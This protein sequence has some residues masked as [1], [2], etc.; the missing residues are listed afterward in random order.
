MLI[1]LISFIFL[2]GLSFNRDL[3]QQ[4]RIDNPTAHVLHLIQTSGVAID[5]A[6][7]KPGSFI[8][9][10]ATTGEV[11]KLRE[12]GLNPKVLIEDLENFYQSRLTNDF[13][14]LDR[15]F[16]YGSMG[17]YYTLDEIYENLV[18]LSLNYPSLVGDIQV[19]G[20]SLEGRDIW[21]I[22]LSDNVDIDEDEPEVLY[23]GLHHAREPM[24][25][26]NLFYFMYWLVENY[27]TDLEARGILDNR[28]LWFIPA[29]NPDGLIYNQSIAPNGGG[30]QRKNARE[31]CSSTPDGTDL[32]RNYSFYWGYNE[33]G[34]SSDGCNETYRGSAPFSE[35]ESQ[36]I[37]D[38]VESHDF[39][40]AFNYHSYSNLMIY[41]YGFNPSITPPQSDLDIFVEYA[42][43][44]T[45]FNGYL[46][47]TGIETVGYTVNGEAC[48]WMYGEH[49]IIAFTPEIGNFNDGFWPSTNRIVPL[50][51]ENLYPNKFLARAA[52]SKYSL[53][54]SIDEGPYA[55]GEQYSINISIFNQGLGNSNG[56]VVLEV[57]GDGN[58]I[59]SD[60]TSDLSISSL[61]ARET[62]NL[63][64]VISFSVSP[65]SQAGSSENIVVKVFDGDSFIE[66]IN[67]QI[68]I[69]EPATLAEDAFESNSG[70]TAGASSD[71]ASSGI[72]ERGVPNQTV[73][74]GIIV[75]TGQDHSAVGSQCYVTGNT[76]GGS[77][78]TDDVDGGRTT[79]LSPAYDIEGYDV[80]LV[81]YWRWYTNNVGDNPNTDTWRVDVSSD[82]GVSWVNIEST[83]QSNPS[84]LKQ[85][86]VLTP[87][88]V[89]LSSTLQ[90]RF[91][92]EDSFNSGDTGTGGSIVEA[93]VD[94][95]KLEVFESS[96]S[97]YSQGD[98][99]ID[100][101]INILDIVL[102]VGYVLGDNNLNDLQVFL[103]DI[104]NDGMTNILDIVQVVSVILGS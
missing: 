46:P 15:D 1:K 7:S 60:S 97:T 55:I 49:Q 10:A 56:E 100:G 102:M 103:S 98:V 61:D 93:A 42:D 59:F 92:A 14:D 2:L 4:I 89:D 27:E 31:T 63:N 68:I 82:G 50:C 6:H 81:S 87:E 43:D 69:G 25:Y 57:E 62:V 32:N 11:L 36:A 66:S 99:N 3:Y 84:W 65:S 41:P 12:I 67:L 18:D 72:W 95:F 28:E 83:N 45:Q 16:D 104:N 47:G 75:Q 40:I 58:I 85:E 26:M 73:Y 51:E 48:D 70:W 8:E 86:I 17:G 9:F 71:N 38:F 52:G 78:G 74:N 39:P 23:T 101:T 13:S 94:D 35:P 90:F 19:I 80:A 5:H 20:S 54:A 64:E 91:V 34:S 53:T 79:L 33:E 96:G 88:L 77:V 30:L 76:Q 44:M 22:K 21:A 29:V 24:S 37:R